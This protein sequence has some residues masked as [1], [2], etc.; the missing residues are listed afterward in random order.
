MIDPKELRI[1]NYCK[2]TVSGE[3][4]LVD[5]ITKG[6]AGNHITGFY[7]VNREKYPLPNGWEAAPIPITPEWLERL[8]FESK[9]DKRIRWHEFKKLIGKYG[10]RV[11]QVNFDK[12]ELLSVWIVAHDRF[13]D[14]EH[15]KYIHQLQ[16]LYF[17]LTGQELTIKN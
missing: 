3:W 6:D 7:V 16:N 10:V 11:L 2:D 1:G 12:S 17:A 14:H 13:A 15:I 5:E 9:K 4:L 8:G